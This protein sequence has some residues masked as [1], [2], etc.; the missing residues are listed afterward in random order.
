MGL[1]FYILFISHFSDIRI[2]IHL[3]VLNLARIILSI[4][5]I[6]TDKSIQIT[7]QILHQ[8]ASESNITKGDKLS[9]FQRY[10]GSTIFHIKNWIHIRTQV[11]TKNITNQSYWTIESIIGKNTAIIEP[12]FGIKFKI[13]I[14]NAQ[15]SAKS[16]QIDDIKV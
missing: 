7:H 3:V 12:I 9:L 8:N 16:S 13:N 5:I 2:A 11:V 4:T 14:K 1:F 10:L 6:G 15:N